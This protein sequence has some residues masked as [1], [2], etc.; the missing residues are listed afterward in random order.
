MALLAAPMTASAAGDDGV[1]AQFFAIWD[2]NAAVTP[3]AVHALYAREV[4]Y[5][6]ETL[7]ADQVFANK[8]RFIRRWPDRR[9]AVVP[10]TVAKGC[11]PAQSR[12]HV[13]AV[14][15]YHAQSATRGA[16]AGGYTRVSLDLVR[17]NG[18]LKI[19][20]ESGRRV[21]RSSF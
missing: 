10:G 6:G 7:T 2:R 16:S 20:R 4:D 17:E 1:V 18:E 8:Q 9:Y 14:L 11:D 5:Y 12:C 3:E 15:A 19:A 21:T 13:S